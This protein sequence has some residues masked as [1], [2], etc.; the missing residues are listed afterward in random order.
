MDGL[1]EPQGVLV[2]EGQLYVV[3]AGKKELV[4][5]DLKSKTRTTIASN[6]P[7]G[8]PAGVT[9]KPLRGIQPVS[10]PQGPFAG[11]A[12]SPDG[13][14]YVSADADGTVLALRKSKA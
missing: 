14:L 4:A 7:V 12:A 1:K 6:L 13:T 3:D 2:H 10:G 5:F 9:A 8:T 11:I